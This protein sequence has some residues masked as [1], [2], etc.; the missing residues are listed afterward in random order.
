MADSAAGTTPCRTPSRPACT[1]ATTPVAGSASS[2]GTQSAT[3]THSTSP[4]VA[5]TSASV[6]GHRAVLGAVDDGDPGA[7]HL[8][9]PDQPV[10]GRRRARAATRGPVG[11]DGGRVVADV[12]AEVERVVGSTDRPP[13]RS[14]T[15][16]RGR[17]DGGAA[18]EELMPGIV[19]GVSP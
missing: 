18:G 16:R 19:P 17:T 14:V 9:H 12:V 6:A 13:R 11:G 1:A 7:V 8:V 3:S 15:T 4:G 2:T 10:L 5:V